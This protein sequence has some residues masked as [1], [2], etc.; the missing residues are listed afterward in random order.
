M[1]NRN[2]DSLFRI[3]T[4]TVGWTTHRGSTPC[5][6]KTFQNGPVVSAAQKTKESLRPA[7]I[8]LFYIT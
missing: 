4:K 1:Q 2:R 8:L 7:V 6:C 3:F 5:K